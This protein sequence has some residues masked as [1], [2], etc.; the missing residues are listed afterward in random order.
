MRG[1]Y[2][3]LRRISICVLLISAASRGEAYDSTQA[4]AN[5]VE[6]YADCV[7][8]FNFVR[9]DAANNHWD[10]MAAEYTVTRDTALQF[11]IELMKDRPTGWAIPVVK[12]EIA[13]MSE[14]LQEWSSTGRSDGVDAQSTE[15][16]VTRRCGTWGFEHYCF[17]NA[18]ARTR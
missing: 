2:S 14:L 1:A 13:W 12:N 18:G 15:K 8:Y 17:L 3:A 4:L 5:I 11:Y 16:S 7:T 9:V 6:D 10:K